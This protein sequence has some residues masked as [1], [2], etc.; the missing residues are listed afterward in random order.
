MPIRTRMIYL[1][2]TN[3]L[4]NVNFS[5]K[6]IGEEI[7]KNRRISQT[8]PV[9]QTHIVSTYV[10]LTFMII[11][12]KYIVYIAHNAL[13]IYIILM[14]F[15]IIHII[16]CTQWF[17]IKLSTFL[18]EDQAT[19]HTRFLMTNHN[20]IYQS[21]YARLSIFHSIFEDIKYY[22]LSIT[23]QHIMISITQG[24]II[25]LY[26]AS[27][28][29]KSYNIKIISNIAMLIMYQYNVIY[30]I[31][32]FIATVYGITLCTK[33][34]DATTINMKPES[35]S[36]YA[37]TLHNVDYLH[38]LSN[39][40]YTFSPGTIYAIYGDNGSGKTT[41]AGLITQSLQPTAGCIQ[42]N[43]SQYIYLSQRNE[44]LDEEISYLR[45]KCDYTD[46]PLIN[47]II[48]KSHHSNAEKYILTII[49]SLITL[50]ESDSALLIL[51]ETMDNMDKY[52]IQ[53]T[54]NILKKHAQNIVVIII[55]HRDEIIDQCDE[56]MCIQSK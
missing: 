26:I 51:D 50:Q 3:H 48:N 16:M 53:E 24:L 8:I 45:Q 55:S 31:Y 18:Y 19:E 35:E 1:L 12:Y 49:L 39:I 4:L 2:R 6:N 7:S 25:V 9:L 56:K 44:I 10:N 47:K 43:I 29:F 13:Y 14:I 33:H 46:H 22:S 40:S 21:K 15:L 34:D 11:N 23:Y 20:R 38:I 28:S 36:I 41:L 42:C 5:M 37:I 52:L 27:L 32:A 54:F 30:H 17:Q